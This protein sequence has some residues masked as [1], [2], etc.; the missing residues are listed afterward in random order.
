MVDSQRPASTS[1][2]AEQH[3]LSREPTHRHLACYYRC[4]QHI[5]A[6][7]RP[8]PQP[9]PLRVEGVVPLTHLTRCKGFARKPYLANSPQNFVQTSTKCPCRPRTLVKFPK[10]GRARVALIYMNN[11]LRYMNS[12]IINPFLPYRLYD[13]LVSKGACIISY[14]IRRNFSAS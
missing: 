7:K 3:H 14:N 2:R 8:R 1:P 5:Q 9:S 12:R 13:R 11:Q 10:N 6:I 4:L